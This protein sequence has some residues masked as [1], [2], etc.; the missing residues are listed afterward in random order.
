M[1]NVAGS[2]LSNLSQCWVTK[3]V[4]NVAEVA[5]RLH[6]PYGWIKQYG[7]DSAKYNSRADEKAEI[8]ILKKK[9]KRITE[10]HNILKKPVH[11]SS[12]LE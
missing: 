2:A 9:L 6:S 5:K 12:H 8:Q 3:R 10:E 4:H 11:F 1:H 7:P